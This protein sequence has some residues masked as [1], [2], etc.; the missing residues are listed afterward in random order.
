MLDPADVAQGW[1][2]RGVQDRGLALRADAGDERQPVA[3]G[4]PGDALNALEAGGQLAGLATG[5]RDDVDLAL[6]ALTV[7]Q[8]G[9]PAPV[10][11]PG[12]CSVSVG[13]A[14]QLAGLAA[15]V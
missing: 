4:A 11:R 13:P 3:A 15:G 1:R 8:E 12:R 6:L 5:G 10:R 7:G 9:Q 2:V 14:G